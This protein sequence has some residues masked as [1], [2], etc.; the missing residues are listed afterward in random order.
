MKIILSIIVFFMYFGFENAILAQ[1]DFNFFQNRYKVFEPKVHLIGIFDTHADNIE[2][3]IEK[4][5]SI[6]LEIIFNVFRSKKLSHLL[7]YRILSGIAVTPKNI[8]SAINNLIVNPNDTIVF[9]YSGHGGTHVQYGHY[10]AM[11]YGNVLRN[12]IVPM[13]IAKKPRLLVVLT[14]SCG[15]YVNYNISIVN[16]TGFLFDRYNKIKD[17][18]LKRKGLVDV[19]SAKPGEYGYTHLEKGGIWTYSFLTVLDRA[20]RYLDLNSDN[21]IAWSEILYLASIYT[22]HN[23]SNLDQPQHPYIFYNMQTF[24]SKYDSL[25]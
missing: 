17:L 18:F 20:D 12:H 7:N 23:T 22:T 11:K 19:N 3:G 25:Q 8:Y 9:Y 1:F 4:D 24:P 15:T 16:P 2:I 5:K 13:M 14:D 6:L 21:F 10:L